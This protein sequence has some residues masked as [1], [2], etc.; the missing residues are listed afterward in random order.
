M[1]RREWQNL[2][3]VHS[4]TLSCLRKHLKEEEKKYA[5]PKKEMPDELKRLMSLTNDASLA[6]NNLSQT[7][8]GKPTLSPDVPCDEFLPSAIAQE[9]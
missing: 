1:V 2:V 9:R 4:D 8:I 7:I 3:D 6:F 5:T